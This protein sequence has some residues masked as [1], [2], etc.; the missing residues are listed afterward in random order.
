MAEDEESI[1]EDTW[2]IRCAFG[3]EVG[4][5]AAEMYVLGRFQGSWKLLVFGNVPIW[6]DVTGASVKCFRSFLA[7]WKGDGGGYEEEA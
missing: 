4:N 7:S 5:G 3:G 2:D 1:S 6:V